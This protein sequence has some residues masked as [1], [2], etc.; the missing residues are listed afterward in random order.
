[1]AIH[2][3]TSDPSGLLTAFKKAIDDRRIETWAYDSQGDFTHTPEQ[4]K[5]RAW[6]RP[7]VLTGELRLNILG[8]NDEPLK[9]YMYAAY[10][11]RFIESMLT[12]FDNAFTLAVASALIETGDDVGKVSN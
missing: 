2:F 6:L 12:H 7:T 3:Y 10:H 9:K 1:M 11:G 8:R 4:W 5:Y